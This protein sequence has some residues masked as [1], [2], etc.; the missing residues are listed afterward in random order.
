MKKI[1]GLLL[2]GGLLFNYFAAKA[3]YFYFYPPYGGAPPQ[4][5]DAALLFSRTNPGGSARI[6]AMG[7]AQVSLGG[8][9]S[10]AFSNPAGL[11]MYNHSEFT[12][13]LGVNSSNTSSIYNNATTTTASTSNFLPITG[14]S[15]VFHNK[16]NNG[17]LLGGTLGLS[18][19]RI[20]DF[21]STF[22]YQG[23]NTNNSII[24]FFL[25]DANNTSSLNGGLGPGNLF[26]TATTAGLLYESPTRL[27]YDN[28]L[29]NPHSPTDSTHYTS[30]VPAN[31]NNPI[32]H[33]IVQT[34]GCQFQGN[35][36]YGVNLGDKV[37]IGG[38]IGIPFL[39]YQNTKTYTE[40]FG[41]VPLSSLTMNESLS[42]SGRGINVTLGSIFRPLD[43]LQVGLSVVTP[44]WYS[45]TDNYSASLG[46]NWSPSSF[47][48]LY[49]TGV[50]P[51]TPSSTDQLTTSYSF[52]TP[53]KL[54]VGAT[55]F[56]QKSG[57]VTADIEY[58]DYGTSHYSSPSYQYY[59]VQNS[60]L[61]FDADNAAIRSDYRSVIN[62]RMGGEYRLNKFRIR[63]GY[64]LMPNPYVQNSTDIQ[65]ES[66]IQSFTAGFGYRSEKFFVDLAGIYTEA[67]TS[68][69]RRY[70]G[71]YNG[72]LIESPLVTTKTTNTKVMVTVGFTLKDSSG[73]RRS[74][75]GMGMY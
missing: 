49:P 13:S 39:S 44:T 75:R 72:N 57:F 7:G 25:A 17:K 38:G 15:L 48:T 14:I 70:E 42:K 6:Q 21:N 47:T 58:L 29:I 12:F 65:I 74:R 23:V 24:D 61:S 4:F 31:P 33:E 22:E 71:T 52:V 20:N 73:N 9:Y 19:N 43:F 1:V 8:D 3:Q 10:S 68:T 34:T 56:I 5:S 60:N 41:N 28:Y 51:T 59:Y 16:K 46:T 53:W 35:I 2:W 62:F 30:D 36:S 54:S 64:N 40:T 67:G 66:T 45:M 37:F 26:Y 50:L 18:L 69:Y 55:Y 11:G 27:A 32:Q 63:A